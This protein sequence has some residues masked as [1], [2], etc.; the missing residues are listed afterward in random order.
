MIFLSLIFKGH[1]P[2]RRGFQFGAS[3]SSLL[4][5]S[6]RP[7]VV[8]VVQLLGCGGV[9]VSLAGAEPSGEIIFV[10]VFKVRG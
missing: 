5:S 6:A 10:E 7:C 4:R 2:C 1:G 3:G 9:V 8:F